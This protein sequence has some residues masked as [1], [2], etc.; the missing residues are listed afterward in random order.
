MFSPVSICWLV[1][2]SR[3]LHKNYQTDFYETWIEDE[4]RPRID[5]IN[6]WFWNVFVNFS[7]NNACVSM[8][9]KTR[10]IHVTGIYD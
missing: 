2:L 3:G 8:K 6:F 5:P 7:G 9:K 1:D 10:H 4:S